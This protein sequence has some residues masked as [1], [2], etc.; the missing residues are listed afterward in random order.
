MLARG[1]AATFLASTLLVGATAD[2]RVE[3][4]SNYTKSQAFSGA[5][6]FLRVDRG[7][8][9]VEKDP[10]AGY[11]LFRYPMPGK[12]PSSSGS[13]EVVETSQGT[14]IYVQLPRMPEYHELVLRDA[15]LKRLREEYGA[16][17]PKAKPPAGEDPKKPG[18][19]PKPAEPAPAEK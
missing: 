10:E 11:V 15:L 18:S 4:S 5:L 8:D 1:L 3:A 9:V 19:E 17:P 7:Y 2:A 12:Q 6:R 13:V 16:P 14:K